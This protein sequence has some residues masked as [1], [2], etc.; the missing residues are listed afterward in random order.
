MDLSQLGKQVSTQAIDHLV[1]RFITMKK[2]RLLLT[3]HMAL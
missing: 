2:H 1:K 3:G